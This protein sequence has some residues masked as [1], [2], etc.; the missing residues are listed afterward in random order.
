MSQYSQT[1][2]TAWITARC[3]VPAVLVGGGLG[4]IF[5]R[6]PVSG[7]LAVIIVSVAAGWWGRNMAR[8]T[9]LGN[10]RRVAW[11]AG[12]AVGPSVVLVGVSLAALEATLV[13]PSAEA[14]LP[15]HVV[16]SL[17][18]VPAALL[19]A[20]I[21]GFALGSGAR[22]VRL[23]TSLAV[24]AGLSG[25]LAFLIIDLLMDALGWRVG[26]PHAGERATMV[27]V[28][29]FG[30]IG[31]A[32]AAGGAL[33]RRLSQLR[34]LGALDGPG[35]RRVNAGADWRVSVEENLHQS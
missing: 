29:I 27:V 34:R 6:V 17:L 18:F 16:S 22:D 33:G 13:G 25:G 9:D 10:E 1:V 2:R 31:A 12:L 3:L 28:T 15:I 11:A 35:L 7:L 26:G 19:I 21:G 20:A 32:L 23:G 30:T 8:L 5:Q 24:R 14:S 4:A